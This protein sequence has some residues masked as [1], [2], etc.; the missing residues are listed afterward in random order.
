MKNKND[1]VYCSI[2]LKKIKVEN[3]LLECLIYLKEITI[4]IE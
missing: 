2:F 3:K 4:I 1:S